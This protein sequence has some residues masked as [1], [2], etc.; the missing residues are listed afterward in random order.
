MRRLFLAVF[1]LLSACN[2]SDTGNVPTVPPLNPDSS[3]PTISAGETGVPIPTISSEH[4]ADV[5]FHGG[6]VLIMDEGLSVAQALAVKDDKIVA[7][8]NDEDV[9]T[10]Q[11]TLTTLIPLDGRTL[12]PG[13]VDA[14]T[15]LL[16]DAAHYG[17]DL[18][19]LQQMALEN[20]I[21]T[22]A[23]LFTSQDFLNEMRD[24]NAENKLR[25]RTSL[26]LIYN[27]NCGDVIG[28]WWK[29]VPPTREAGEMLRIGGVKMFADGGSCNRPALSYETEP[30][31]GLGDL[32]LTGDQIADVV[33]EAQDVGHQ[34]AIHALGDRA[35]EAALDGLQSAMDG[36]PNTHRHRIE[37]NAIL[38]PDLLP[39]YGELDV[40]AT[41]FGTFPSCVDFENPSPP[42]YNEWEWAWDT[43]LDANPGLHVAWHGDDPYIAPISPILELYGLVTRNAASDD[44]TTVCE[45]KDW[46]ADNTLSVEQ[47]LPMMT[48]ESA[49]A[50]FRD[51]EV[52]TLETGKFADLIIL[53]ENPISE[54]P[55]TLLDT[56]VL[57]TMVGG[58]VEWCSPGSEAFCPSTPSLIVDSDSIPFGYVDS[59]TA[60][61]TVSGTL[62]IAGWAL[63]DDGPI[64]R[65]E[66]YLDG[67]YI[68]DAVY[69]VSRPDVANDYPGRDGA[70]NF[71][72]SFELDTTL[73]SN[74]THTFSA[75]A[76]GPS[77]NQ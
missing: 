38:R 58:K 39:R 65:I 12:M 76:Y 71:G 47:A 31:S 41:I 56:Y 52:G 70:P 5:I 68:A 11:G 34:V 7:V 61:E 19:G 53:S 30:G 66:L 51:G 14:H 1:L 25:L 55:D 4:T 17:M 18:D 2:F 15:H 6:N 72:Y 32:Y 29:D 77:G 10:W 50:L 13:F 3:V 24:Y 44:R 60:D 33:K 35:I 49:Y 26:Y 36:A 20:G 23:N 67:E 22:L 46:I 54:D 9:L 21:T 16:N 63:D 62:Y 64:D 37:H 74:G 42:P 73:Y 69:G 27:T 48:R 45:A 57:M 59:P 75:V 43:L 40:V 28:N 8:G